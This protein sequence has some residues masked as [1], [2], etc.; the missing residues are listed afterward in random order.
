MTN[1]EALEEKVGVDLDR[2]FNSIINGQRKDVV[3]EIVGMASP[4]AAYY[5]GCLFARL[6]AQHEDEHVVALRKILWNRF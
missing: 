4:E 5:A 1:E 2:M 3:Q 6:T